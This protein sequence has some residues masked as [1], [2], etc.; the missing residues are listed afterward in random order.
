MD[1]TD[2]HA[3]IDD[4]RQTPIPDGARSARMMQH[5]NMSVRYY[6]PRG[7]DQQT[8][9][10]Q[11]EVYVIASGSGAFVNGDERR[12]FTAGDVIFVPAGRVHRFEDFTEDFAT[13][14]VFYGPKGGERDD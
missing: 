3:S 14:V 9:H 8:P 6:A 12:D 11:D 13:W 2:W 4:A 10:E 7:R 1:K 5:V